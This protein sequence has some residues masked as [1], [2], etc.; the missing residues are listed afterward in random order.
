MNREL[1][2][3]AIDLRVKERLSYSEIRKRLGV[4]KSTLSYWLQDYPLSQDEVL[5]LRR[6]G[7]KKGEASRERYRITMRAKEAEKVRQQYDKEIARIASIS[8][9][10]YYLAGL[11]LYHGEGAKRKRGQIVL[12]NTDPHLLQFFIQ[13]LTDF[14]AIDRSKLKVQL[15]LYETMD[16]EK[17]LIFWQNTL[18]LSPS[19]FYKSSVRT[20]RSHSFSY[21]SGERHGTCQVYVF[22]VDVER[23]VKAA[24]SAF[25]DSWKEQYLRD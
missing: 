17:E 23:R 13:W 14:F 18:C 5:E 25:R 10:A 22:G 1:R 4:A 24:M 19:Q 6:A 16:I 20:L 3:R 11:M 21:D 8:K 7:W 12:T 9:Q 15:H 2:Q